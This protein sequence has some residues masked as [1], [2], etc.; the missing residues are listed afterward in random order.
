MEE[1]LLPSSIPG[2][3]VI[4]GLGL[5][6]IFFVPFPKFY[7]FPCLSLEVPTFQM[8]NDVDGR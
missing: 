6:L 2:R 3:S 7:C 5:L 1:I 8:D 4:Y